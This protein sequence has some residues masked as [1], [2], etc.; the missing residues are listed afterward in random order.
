LVIGQTWWRAALTALSLC[1]GL[2]CLAMAAARVGSHAAQVA[3]GVM[4]LAMAGMLSPWG[5]PVPTWAGAAVFT[6]V[7][8]WFAADALGAR[9]GPDAR[10]LA[11]S[12]A[13]MVVMYLM[14]PHAAARDGGAGSGGHGGHLA[15]AGEGGV[16][17]L[18]LGALGLLLAGYFVWH[19]WIVVERARARRTTGSALPVAVRTSPA[20]VQ[21]VPHGI[22]SALMVAMFLGAA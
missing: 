1:S 19:T 7:G 13:A 12:A 6:V 8:A 15:A 3:H 10:H 14:S 17:G 2:A 16:P 9:P 5:D 20:R 11:I 21:L 4:G 18:L 22:M